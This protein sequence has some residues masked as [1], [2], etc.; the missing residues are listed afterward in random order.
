MNSSYFYKDNSDD[1]L[2][3]DFDF[4]NIYNIIRLIATSD[5]ELQKVLNIL[6]ITQDQSEQEQNIHNFIYECYHIHQDIHQMYDTNEI[7][8]IKAIYQMENSKEKIQRFYEFFHSVKRIRSE[9]SSISFIRLTQNKKRTFRLN[10][11]IELIEDFTLLEG[12][13][14]FKLDYSLKFISGFA[15]EI[16][17]KAQRKN[18]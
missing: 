4:K 8:R 16:E 12:L 17:Q 3:S 14:G 2:P 15:M 7:K 1:E 18:K 9:K 13:Y 6:M 10:Q 5:Y 11:L